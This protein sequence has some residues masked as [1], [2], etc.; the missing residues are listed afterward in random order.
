MAEPRYPV[1]NNTYNLLQMTASK[2]EA[3]QAYHTYL[4][5]ADDRSKKVIQ[6]LIDEDTE[7][8]KQLMQTLKEALR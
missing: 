5:D 4:K 6:Q 7:H 8:A 3:L 1:D 2:L